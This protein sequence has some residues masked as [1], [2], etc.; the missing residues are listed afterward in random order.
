MSM[1]FTNFTNRPRISVNILSS[2][3]PHLSQH[4]CIGTE[5]QNK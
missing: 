5:S 2:L 4:I 3:K 1:L